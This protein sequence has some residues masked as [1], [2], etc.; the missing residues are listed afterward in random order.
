MVG[1][2]QTSPK[3]RGGMG[4]KMNEIKTL[5]DLRETITIQAVEERSPRRD[6]PLFSFNGS[7]Q[8]SLIT[9][10]YIE[11]E[12]LRQEAIKCIK[13]HKEIFITIPDFDISKFLG[14]K[15]KL[16]KN[17]CI[18]ELSDGQEIK[19]R[20][21][22]LEKIGLVL[23]DWIKNFLNITEEDLSCQQ[24]MMDCG[25]DECGLCDNCKTKEVK[26]GR[27]HTKTNS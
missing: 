10:R 24:P 12:K 3:R 15:I 23:N 14:G 20:R 13:N 26:Y 2:G 4:L 5:E 6:R 21:G 18:F 8:N 19:M 7:L 25:S 27:E 1:Q 22:E 17:Q 16:P 11:I 9:T